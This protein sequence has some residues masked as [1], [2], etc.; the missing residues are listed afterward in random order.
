MFQCTSLQVYGMPHFQRQT[1]KVGLNML[2]PSYREASS[3]PPHSCKCWSQSSC[4]YCCCCCWR[5]KGCWGSPDRRLFPAA[6]GRR[7]PRASTAQ[8][9]ASTG[10]PAGCG[11][12]GPSPTWRSAVALPR[13][14]VALA[15]PVSVS[16]VCEVNPG[17]QHYATA[18]LWAP[19]FSSPMN[20]LVNY[21]VSLFVPSC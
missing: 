18:P 16:P 1:Q 20:S 21:F 3:P 2:G 8:S 19:T 15:V 7:S 17:R 13:S 5:L 12:H 11:S 4:C 14:A 10:T 9:V 6:A